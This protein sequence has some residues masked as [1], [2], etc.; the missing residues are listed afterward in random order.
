MGF[1]HRLI[2]RYE[3]VHVS[4]GILGNLMFVIG[5][6]LFF[7]SFSGLYN[8]AVWLFILGSTLMLVGAVGEELK[9]FGH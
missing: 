7:D 6:V 3:I 1:V 9:R 4:I 5:S 2:K 8:M